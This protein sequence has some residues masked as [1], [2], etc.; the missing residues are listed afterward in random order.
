MTLY[1]KY[2]PQKIDELDLENVREQLKKIVASKDLPHAFLF[3]GPK[4]AGKTS[5]AR[6]LA[7]IVNCQELGKDYEPCNKCQSCAEINRGSSLD[8]IEIDA[9][10][11]RGIDDVRALKENI[12][13]APSSSSKKLYIVDE[14]HMLT[15]EA[16]NALLK[17]LEEPPDHVIFI[18]AT[19]DPQ[20]LPETVRS[21]LVNINFKKA[22]L[23]E[24]SRQI[25]RVSKGEGLTVEKDAVALISK[26]SDG[27]FRDAVKILEQLQILGLKKI[28]AVDV[29]KYLK[30]GSDF[31]VDELLSL[32]KK[33]DLKKALHYVTQLSENGVSMRLVVDSLIEKTR[34]SITEAESVHLIELLIE[35]RMRMK[36]GILPELPL[37][38]AL[39]KFLR[40]R[41]TISVQPDSKKEDVAEEEEAGVS[42]QKTEEKDDSQKEVTKSTNDESASFDDNNKTSVDDS[43]WKQI[44]VMAKAR[45]TS[46]EALLRAAEPIGFDGS[47][48]KLGVYYKFHKERLE[49]SQ[50][51]MILEEVASK[52]LGDKVNVI[53][54][55]TEKKF[56]PTPSK[57]LTTDNDKD[58]IS[59]AKEI[60]G[61]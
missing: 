61:S 1:L 41:N 44:L 29:E 50:N 33:K 11:N 51:K 46:V 42:D 10:S 38:I 32:I 4:G 9:A 22:N 57:P 27:S 21:R 54:E 30:S 35:A 52:V 23:D 25:E 43:H 3:S 7:K 31:N 18:L 19:T 15:T 28:S 55:L 53:Y 58:I 20:K 26:A 45:N 37:E 48:L 34:E 16:A 14:A 8:V 49:V 47:R 39:S 13:L 12:M 59:T 17:T 36:D 24:I 5:T 40:S 6:I 60:F 56:T 2:R